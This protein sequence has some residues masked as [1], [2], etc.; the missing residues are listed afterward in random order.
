MASTN[1]TPNLNLTQY[2]AT[3]KP[4]WLTDYNNDMKTL[5]SNIVPAGSIV[6]FGGNVIPSGWLACTGATISRVT[7]ARLF[8]AIGTTYGAGDGS[9]TFVL[10]NMSGKFPL[11]VDKT[12]YTLGK[13]GG[14]MSKSLIIENLPPH[15]H[16]YYLTSGTVAGSDVVGQY[17]STKKQDYA[18]TTD[19]AG[20]GQ[21]FDVT[22]SYIAL[23]YIIKI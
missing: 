2:S 9:S 20:A 8:N 10:P 16:N 18:K 7:Y 14:S 23:R 13:T 6:A 1:K 19:F 17:T 11:A 5:D 12:S 4:S 22:P 21:P 15:N 3:D